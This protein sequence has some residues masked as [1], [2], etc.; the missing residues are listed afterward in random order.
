MQI[1]KKGFQKKVGLQTTTQVG[2]IA[3]CQI[4][5]YLTNAEG[6]PC[7]VQLPEHERSPAGSAV[8]GVEVVQVNRPDPE[9]AKIRQ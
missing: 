7:S 5:N 6:I 2:E 8:A 4:I 1:C 9:E 3:I